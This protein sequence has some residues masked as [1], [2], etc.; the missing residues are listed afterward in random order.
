MTDSSVLEIDTISKLAPTP[1][2]ITAVLRSSGLDSGAVEIGTA[3]L[4]LEESLAP[5]G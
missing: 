4:A 2:T 1:F 5:V 3:G